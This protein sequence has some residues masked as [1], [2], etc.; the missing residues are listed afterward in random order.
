ME[1]TYPFMHNHISCWNKLIG[2]RELNI[3][4]RFL[5]FLV[6]R[7]LGDTRGYTHTYTDTQIDRHTQRH[8]HTHIR[9][10]TKLNLKD[11]NQKQTKTHKHKQTHTYAHTQNT[12]SKTQTKNTHK[13][14]NNNTKSTKIYVHTCIIIHSRIHWHGIYLYDL[15][16]ISINHE[17]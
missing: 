5:S 9:T 2:P 16:K 14:A 3:I 11:T 6:R 15:Y 13:H 12:I 17:N 7:L 4:M 1:V 10:H 8:T